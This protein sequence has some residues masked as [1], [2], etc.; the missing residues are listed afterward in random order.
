VVEISPDEDKFDIYEN[1]IR[2]EY[3]LSFSNQLL[4]IGNSYEEYDL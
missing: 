2:P 1:T 4:F 3:P